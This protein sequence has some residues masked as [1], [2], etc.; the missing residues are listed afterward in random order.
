MK[1]IIVI[2]SDK[3]GSGDD[4]LGHKLMGAFLKKLWARKDSPEL[5]ILYN[6]GVRL[7]SK[8]NGYMD[9]MHGLDE[10]GVEIIACGT[11]IDAYDMRAS[12]T[13]GR[14]SNMEEIVDI[15]MKAKK[16]ITI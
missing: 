13:T 11:C 8:E 12:I 14:I 7:L 4:H 3:M 9:V 10:K 5:I 2:N 1:N 6:S 16:V 15:M